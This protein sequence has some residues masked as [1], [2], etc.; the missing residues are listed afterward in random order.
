L[1]KDLSLLWV[2][3]DR[4]LEEAQNAGINCVI[5]RRLLVNANPKLSEP[6]VTEDGQRFEAGE[7]KPFEKLAKDSQGIPRLGVFRADV[8]NLGR[9]FSEGLGNEATLSRIASLSFLISLFFE[10]WVGKVAEDWNRAHGERLYAIYSG[11]DD[12]FFV[13][14]WD[15]VVEFAWVL[16]EDLKRYVGHPGIHISGGMSLVASKYPLAKAAQDAARAEE[17][18][19]SMLWW[20]EQG[21]Q[22][23]KNVFSFLGQPLPWERFGAVRELKAK[24]ERLEESKQMAI[25]RKILMNYALYAEAEERRRQAGRDR[26]PA[27]KPQA[28]YG[29]WNWRIVYLLRRAFGKETNQNQNTLEQ[30]LVREFHV[31]PN[32]QGKPDYARLD[33]VG[34][35]ARWVE[36]CTRKRG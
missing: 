16:N 29:P 26:K 5:M 9:L 10:G 36:L 25:V 17:A 23:R 32:V 31:T 3:K 35:A 33:W 18:A 27:G 7:I 2:L 6:Y 34:V 30:Q 12:L 8:D 15:E 21:N 20:D 13:G 11:G 24:L 28:L 1:P 14:S 19:K 22:R 4:A